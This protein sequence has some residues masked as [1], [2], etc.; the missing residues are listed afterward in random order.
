MLV[1]RLYYKAKPFIPRG[2]QLSLRRIV[3]DMTRRRLQ[4]TWPVFQDRCE[5]PPAWPGWPDGKRFALALTHDVETEIGL[6]RV[7]KLVQLEKE[8]GFRSSF[9][10]VPERYENPPELHR[11]LRRDGFEIGVHGLRHDGKLYFSR[12][13]FDKTC[14]R[15]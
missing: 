11:T 13:I 8:L 7:L 5:P 10:F 4:G 12:R 1:N 6:R 3:V 15:L 2:V 14:E 9:Y